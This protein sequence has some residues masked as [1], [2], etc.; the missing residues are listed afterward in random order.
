MPMTEEAKAAR[1]LSRA[2]SAA[3]QAEAQHHRMEAKRRAWAELGM[4]LTR[5]QAAAGERCRGCG[6]PVIDNLGDW[7]G[8]MYLSA[9]ERLEYDA[10]DAQFR[11]LHPDCDAHRWSMSGSRATH[12]G[13]CC[14]SIP[15]SQAQAEHVGRLLSNLREHRDDELDVWE[16][17]LTCG[18]RVE[19]Q[20]HHTNRAPSV[21]TA[22]CP[23]CGLTR[24]VVL[25]KRILEAAER[26]AE[27]KCQRD[28]ALAGAEREVAKA[29]KAA[30][31]AHRRLGEL[32]AGQ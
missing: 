19:Q 13:L 20:V 31:D 15:M 26:I 17:V 24:G 9:A 7:P 11:E 5:E 32:R 10:A 23:A 29:E 22:A 1:A 6:L 28:E 16:R 8:T 12:C 2:M 14:P 27:S 21:S 3:L 4:H 30:R 25:S 18:H